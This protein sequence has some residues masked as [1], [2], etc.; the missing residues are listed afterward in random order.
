MLDSYNSSQHIGVAAYMEKSMPAKMHALSASMLWCYNHCR[1]SCAWEGWS[2]QSS[3]C[4][5]GGIV[6]V[7]FWRGCCFCPFNALQ[8]RCAYFPGTS[9]KALTSWNVL[10]VPKVFGC[11]PLIPADATATHCSFAA[12]PLQI[13]RRRHCPLP[14]TT[15]PGKNAHEARPA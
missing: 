15:P 12:S 9:H 8:N 7:C 2:V 3:M 14:T 13:W 4:L 10:G 1:A 6:D 11:F 5:G